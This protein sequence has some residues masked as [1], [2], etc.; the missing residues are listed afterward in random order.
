MTADEI[1]AE[2]PKLSPQERR[3]ILDHLIALIEE[4]EDD[5]LEFH[6]RLASEN[7]QMLDRMEAEDAEKKAK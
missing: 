7:F 3:Q 6:R 4:T 1:I 2:L 5:I